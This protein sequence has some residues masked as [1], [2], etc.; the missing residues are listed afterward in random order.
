MRRGVD[1][2]IEAGT[3][4][5]GGH[6]D[7][8]ARHGLG[9]RALLEGAARRHSTRSALCAGPE[10]VFLALRGLRT[11]G[12]RLVRHQQSALAVARW[13][14]A[15]PEVARVLHPALE[16][17]PG[18]AIWK[19]DFSGASGL[20]SVV[21]KPMPDTAAHAF[22]NA[23][24]LFGI[25]ASWG[26]FE[27]LA[28]PFDCARV[29][30]RDHMG[31]GRAGVRF[32]I[33]LEDVGD[34]TADL[35]R[36]F[37]AMRRTASLATI[38][39]TLAALTLLAQ[40]EIEIAQ[41]DEHA[42]PLPE[43]EHRVAPIERIDEQQQPP[44][45]ENNQNAI[46]MTLRPARSDAIH[47]TRKRMVNSACATKPSTTHQSSLHHEDVVQ[48]V[49]DARAKIDQH[50]NL[51]NLRHALAPADQPPAR[52]QIEDADPEPVPHPVVRHAV[53]A[54]PV[55]HVDIGDRR[56]PSR[57]TSAGRKRCRPSK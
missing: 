37:A 46:G 20:F 10:D 52:R 36:G 42:E 4:Y 19:R 17:D 51:R 8:H 39:T 6:S 3:K 45:I 29:P 1:L 28:I 33:G 55:D 47:C 56:S 26:G 18:H 23:L 14:A 41:I 50:S 49:A 16:T 13:L 38:V 9:E 7:L 15:R 2:A 5:L 44:P 12:V 25:G 57:R 40:H 27:S 43:D 32:H 34:L 48:I 24:T 31:A 22:L 35:E 11:M 53:T 54:R 30:H 21:F